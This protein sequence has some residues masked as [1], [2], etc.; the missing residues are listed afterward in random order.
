MAYRFATGTQNVGR[1][2]TCARRSAKSANNGPR[3]VSTVLL[4]NS[5][6]D[7][8]QRC[9]VAPP[10]GFCVCIDCGE[11]RLIRLAASAKHRIGKFLHRT[12]ANFHSLRLSILRYISEHGSGA[13]ALSDCISIGLHDALLLMREKM[14][15]KVTARAMQKLIDSL[16]TRSGLA[17]T[18]SVA[19]ESL[20]QTPPRDRLHCLSVAAGCLSDMS[21]QTG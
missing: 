8:R 13:L 11:Q 10:A 3:Q 6:H 15:C 2:L 20:F 5:A 14:I 4:R 16:A 12:C 9:D 21:K 7:A 1:K 18:P 17:V 19:C